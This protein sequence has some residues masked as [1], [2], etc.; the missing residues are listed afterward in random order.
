[1]LNFFNLYEVSV[2]WG[3]FFYNTASAT[4]KAI[5]RSHTFSRE[6]VKYSKIG[7]IKNIFS[8]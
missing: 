4:R 1:M 3:L 2:T 5:Y 8:A 6:H 7:V